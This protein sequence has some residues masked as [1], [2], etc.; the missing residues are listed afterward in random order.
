[1]QISSKNLPSEV[2][3]CLEIIIYHYQVRFITGIQR[4]LSI[5]NELITST[6][7]GGEFIYQLI[8][9]EHLTKFNAQF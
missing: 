1:M 5:K 7:T 3:P 8:K 6:G 4:W 2:Q 9:K